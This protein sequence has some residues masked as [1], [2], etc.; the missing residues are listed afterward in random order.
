[1]PVTHVARYAPRLHGWPDTLPLRVVALS[2]FHACAP[3]M[4]AIRLRAICHEV[5]DL[6]PDLIVLLGD[7]ASGPR[8]SWP[9]APERWA[10][11]LGAL[12]A[13]LGVHAVLGN[14]DYDGYVRAD[15][16]HGPVAAQRALEAVGI[17]VHTNRAVRLTH[18]DHGFWLAGLGDQ[19]AF[20]QGVR[21]FGRG[22]GVDDLDATLAQV[23]TDEPVILMAHEPDLF[24]ETPD[25]VALTLS[26]HTHAGQVRLFG[27]TPVVPSRHGSRYA[28]GH[29]IEGR[30]QLIV[31]AGLGY[32]GLPIR[33]GTWPE[34]VLVDLGG[35]RQ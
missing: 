13:P 17:P 22:L 19:Y 14:H 11:E 21:G 29:F 12:R 3:Y 33:F 7:Y 10:Q 15:L 25:R 16:A 6:A 35:P 23:D 2:D 26:G 27:R 20:A 34:I 5:A 8:L 31:S 24:P 32:S 18:R 9:L 1:M 28:H 30:K 4:D